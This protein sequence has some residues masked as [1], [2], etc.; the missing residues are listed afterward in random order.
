M[1]SESLISE[2]RREVATKPYVMSHIAPDDLLTLTM[3]LTE[4]ATVVPE[5]PEPYPAVGVDRKD[6]HLYA[7]A[8][9]GQADYLVSGDDHLM[10]VRHIDEVRI[11]S[12][13]EF[14]DALGQE[15]LI[16]DR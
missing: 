13:A 8:L 7:H 3:L 14:L 16:P 4:N 9:L 6:D 5:I 12:P 10:R 2:F 1:T 15:G 11:I